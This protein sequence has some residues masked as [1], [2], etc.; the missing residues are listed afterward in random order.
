[1]RRLQLPRPTNLRV[2]KEVGKKSRVALAQVRYRGTIYCNFAE[3]TCVVHCA[4]EGTDKTE[5]PFP[6]PGL[7]DP[8]ELNLQRLD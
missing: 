2:K 3:E 7:C 8:S 6:R 5:L 4:R 1:M